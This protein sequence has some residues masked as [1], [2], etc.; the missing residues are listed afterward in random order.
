MLLL[1]RFMMVGLLSILIWVSLGN[2][3]SAVPTGPTLRLLIDDSC[4]GLVQSGG[5][6]ESPQQ[7]ARIIWP[8]AAH[9]SHVDLPTL[10]EV[11]LAQLPLG[12]V[13]QIN[14]DIFRV[15]GAYKG[16][17]GGYRL[18]IATEMV[19]GD[20][21]RGFD[22]NLKAAG[23]ITMDL[24]TWPYLL[25]P[26][27][28]FYF[29]YQI[30]DGQTITVP[31]VDEIQGALDRYNEG[32]SPDSEGYIHLN[33][34]KSKHIFE[35]PETFLRRFAGDISKPLSVVQRSF[36][37]DISSHALEAFLLPNSL[38]FYAA[39]VS[40]IGVRFLDQ[41][42][43][44]LRKKMRDHLLSALVGQIDHLANAFAA[45]FPQELKQY[46]T[47]VGNQ[48]GQMK[49]QQSIEQEQ[50]HGLTTPLSALIGNGYLG[51]A[52]IYLTDIQ[53]FFASTMKADESARRL[54]NE[55]SRRDR[56]S[57]WSDYEPL[58]KRIIESYDDLSFFVEDSEGQ[59]SITH[60]MP[61]L[62][63][64]RF[65][66]DFSRRFQRLESIIDQLY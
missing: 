15:I 11:P 34:Y 2:S 23:D 61:F 32:L 44:R 17:H 26:R 4:D 62:D 60:L 8:D 53:A 57:H 49:S 39:K 9:F 3:V 27:A 5:S 10:E 51:S 1:L 63:D 58:N 36:F 45:Y 48:I 55:F 52:T 54:V 50:L 46:F 42:G 38:I 59:R 25:G 12:L 18:R 19:W 35:N 66:R 6:T 14:T 30:L 7:K 33:Y 41:Y 16:L 28:A 29:G 22:P 37:H 47:E 20:A 21:R 65:S 24:R 43:H 64:F 56:L 13:D 40:S 31:T